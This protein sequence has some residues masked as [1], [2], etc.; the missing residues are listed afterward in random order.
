VK[1]GLA[2]EFGPLGVNQNKLHR[3]CLYSIGC[4]MV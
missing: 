1:F 2:V 3:G 4:F